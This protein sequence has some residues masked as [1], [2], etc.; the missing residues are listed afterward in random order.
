VY[1]DDYRRLYTSLTAMHEKLV[2]LG[3]EP[4]SLL[5]V[6]PTRLKVSLPGE[7]WSESRA[8]LSQRLAQH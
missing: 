1:A 3:A 7:S 4:S 2:Q 8:K 5:A 6:A